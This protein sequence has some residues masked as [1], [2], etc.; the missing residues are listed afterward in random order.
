MSLVPNSLDVLIVD[1]NGTLNKLNS[2]TGNILWQKQIEGVKSVKSGIAA[3][4]KYI[5]LVNQNNQ[6][7]VLDNNGTKVWHVNIDSNISAAPFIVDGTNIVVLRS[8]GNKLI[9][10]G[11]DSQKL[12]WQYERTAP[13]LLL[14]SKR[15]AMISPQSGLLVG[16]FHNAKLASIDSKTGV[17]KWEQ[18]ISYSKGVTDSERI[19]DIVGAPYVNGQNLCT[20]SY[21]GKIGCFDLSNGELNWDVNFSSTKN[22]LGDNKAIYATNTTSNI[23]AYSYNGTNLWT[24]NQLKNRNISDGIS[25]DGY[26]L[27]SD[28][29]GILQLLN[30]NN[31]NIVAQLQLSP[32]AT[33]FVKAGSVVLVRANN[34]D[35]YGVN[36]TQ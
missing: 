27:Y 33:A 19:N 14:H 5:A 23:S 13:N 15:N 6:L 22:I 18:T 30:K 9:A 1:K 31:G 28:Y 24:Q 25:L 20:A 12:L 17:Q 11:L 36:I 35:V 32:T 34:G 16:G 7:I 21:Q 29:E 26:V 3:N 8:I 10:Y 2:Q 4:A